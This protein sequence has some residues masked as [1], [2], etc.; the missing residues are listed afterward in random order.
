M[1]S[2]GTAAGVKAGSTVRDSD[3]LTCTSEK[4]IG[5]KTNV[6]TTYTAAIRAACTVRSN[7]AL[8]DEE[9]SLIIC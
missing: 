1:K 9:F 7:F 5:A 3:I 6:T 4:D 8:S 2:P